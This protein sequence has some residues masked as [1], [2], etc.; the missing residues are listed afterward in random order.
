MI[1]ATSSL[2]QVAT[3]HIHILCKLI[4]PQTSKTLNYVDSILV[5]PYFVLF[6]GVWIY[7]RH[8][9]NLC[10]LWAT[11]T[12]FKTIGPYELNWETEQYKCWI[13]Q[14]ITFALLA[15]LQAVNLFWLFLILRIAKRYIFDSDL[16]DERSDNE[17]SEAEDE[18]NKDKGARK[19]L[20]NNGG[21]ASDTPTVL[22][23]G[24]SVEPE[25]KA[26]GA[27]DRKKRK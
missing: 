6:A 18:E 16:D 22:I 3:L 12:E 1:S 13:S 14:Y 9:I 24:R 2:P 11:L 19:G 26:E 10:I 4:W 15:C 17:E 27:R 5:G 25:T 23:N 7:L 20:E 21:I 8:Y